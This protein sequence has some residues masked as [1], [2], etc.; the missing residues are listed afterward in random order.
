MTLMTTWHI[1]GFADSFS[2]SSAVAMSILF[3]TSPTFCML[4]AASATVAAI[5]YAALHRAA[6]PAEMAQIGVAAPPP[7]AAAAAGAPLP[8]PVLMKY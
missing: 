7:P 2:P 8:V 5:P 1:G 6:A 3:A 4:F